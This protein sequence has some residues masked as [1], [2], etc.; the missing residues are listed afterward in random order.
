MPESVRV[1]LR[2][3]VAAL[4]LFTSEFLPLAFLPTA[5]LACAMRRFSIVSQT[6]CKSL[7]AKGASH[8]HPYLFKSVDCVGWRRTERHE[9][10]GSRP[11]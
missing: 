8:E 9:Y 3:S 7:F 5:F 10:T 1:C 6:F 4:A 2:T 11:G